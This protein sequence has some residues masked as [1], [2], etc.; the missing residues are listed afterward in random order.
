MEAGIIP[1]KAAIDT[2]S[3]KFKVLKG[4]LTEAG[5]N[6]RIELINNIALTESKIALIKI[7]KEQDQFNYGLKET[8]KTQAQFNNLKQ[9]ENEISAQGMKAKQQV[10]DNYKSYL[11]ENVEMELAQ[12]DE[13]YNA[14]L[15]KATAYNLNVE[16]LHQQHDDN[17]TKI[18][19]K[20]AAKQNKIQSAVSAFFT[21]TLGINASAYGEFSSFMMANLDKNSKSQFAVWKAFSIQQ[22]IVDTYRA[23][24]AGYAAMAGIP[25]VGPGLGAAAAAA[26]ITVGLLRVNEIRKLKFGGAAEHGALIQGSASGVNMLAGERGKSELVLPLDDEAGVEKFNKA[27]GGKGTQINISFN[28]CF[29]ATEEWPR[30]AREKIDRELYKLYQD[31]NSLFGKALA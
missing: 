7:A 13:K 11:S 19:E 16:A 12:E 20:S 24:N 31:K 30:K 22:A 4:E 26:A 2:I 9:A 28:D 5:G 29:W 8:A 14:L 21:R 1:I 27:Y 18:K 3:V 15:E 6:K 23:A 10:M 25:I 17:I